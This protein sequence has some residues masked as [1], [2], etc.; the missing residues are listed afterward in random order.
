MNS[1][2]YPFWVKRIYRFLRYS[3]ERKRFFRE[4]KIKRAQNDNLKSNFDP[5]CKNLIVFFVPGADRKTGLETI[6]GGVISLVSLCEESR[7]LRAIHQAETLMC[8]FPRDFLFIKYK[9]FENETDLFRFEQ[10]PDYFKSVNKLILHVPELLVPY[11]KYL[12]LQPELIWLNKIQHV[13]INVVNASI[14][15]MPSPSQ[16][17]ALTEI[18]DKVTITA[19]HSKYCTFKERAFYGKPLHKFSAWIS[20]EQYIFQAYEKKENILVV[21]P[22]SSPYREQILHVLTGIEELK[23]VVLQNLSHKEF[24]E[25]ITKA[26][27]ALTFGEGLDG[28]ILEP[29]FSGSFGM[30]VYNEDFFTADF[31]QMPGIYSSY[32][33]LRDSIVNDILSLDNA[34]SYRSAQREQF[35]LCAKHYNYSQYQENIRKFYLEDYTFK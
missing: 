6:S 17:D 12:L 32:E 14:L 31:K 7:K 11:L 3:D 15:L 35:V 18:A 10:L 1:T 27:W 26:K 20:P 19:A 2:R 4:I 34:V 16:V 30:A 21:S 24:K 9:N 29:I 8:I 5:V 33:T 22:D 28:Y 25:M 23:V 13:H